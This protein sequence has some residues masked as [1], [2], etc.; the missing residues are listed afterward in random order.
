MN[1]F[2]FP[3]KTLKISIETVKDY[4]F[5]TGLFNKD[6]KI[7]KTKDS[8]FFPVISKDNLENRFKGIKII[9]E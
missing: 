9:N 7:I 2:V 6:Y 1:N 3:K 4:L 8:V 5:K